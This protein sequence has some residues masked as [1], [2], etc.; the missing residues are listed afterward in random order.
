MIAGCRAERGARRDRAVVAKTRVPGGHTERRRSARPRRHAFADSTPRIHLGAVLLGAR[1]RQGSTPWRDETV[2]VRPAA[3]A[4]SALR[5][6]ARPAVVWFGES[7]RTEDLRRGD[8]RDRVRCV[9]RPSARRPSCIRPP[10]SCTK[11][12]STAR[13]PPRST[14]KRRPHLR[15]STSPSKV[16]QKSCCRSSPST[17]AA[18]EIATTTC[19]F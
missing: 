3:A 9:P 5:R 16:A 7:L 4:M 13:S 1:A 19:D 6:H 12:G 15:A 10:D 14:S 11:R 2:P 8:S 17:C 18:P